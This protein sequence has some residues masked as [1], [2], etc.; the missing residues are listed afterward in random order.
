M[1]YRNNFSWPTALTQH[2]AVFLLC[3][4]LQG[5]QTALHAGEPLVLREQIEVASDI[6]TLG[7]LFE[8]AHDERSVAVFRSPELG[9]TGIVAA[10][11]IVNAASQHGREWQNPG[12]ILKVVVKRPGRLV[13]LD[14]VRA[15]IGKH[16]AKDDEKWSV[17]FGRNARP[18]HIDHRVTGTLSVKQMNLQSTSGSFRAVVTVEDSP[19][20]VQDK[21]FTGRAFQSVETIVPARLIERGA[22][23]TK[24]DLKVVDLPQSRVSTSAIEDIEAAVGMA[25]RQ[26]LIIDRPIRRGDLEHPKLVKR[27][28]LVTITYQVPGMVLKAKGRALGDAARGQ[29]VQIVNLQSKRTIE[30]EVTGT[31]TVSVSGLQLTPPALSKRT[32]E[33]RDKGATG[34]N[35]FYVR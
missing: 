35:S 3:F 21:T 33:S 23:I 4:T 22:T 10:K 11:R 32:A 9:T 16:A 18:F 8:N 1:N 12:G 30:A 31:S 34:P 7:D 5:W 14:E 2:L 25:A 28:S 17:S 26:R 13:T 6:V 29:S 19:F 15:V 24:D 27:N 20:P